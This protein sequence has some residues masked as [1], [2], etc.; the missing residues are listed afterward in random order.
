MLCTCCELCVTK[1]E[2]KDNDVIVEDGI[3]LEGERLINEEIWPVLLENEDKRGTVDFLEDVGEAGKI[4]DD[5]KPFEDC[6]GIEVIDNVLRVEEEADAECHNEEEPSRWIETP[7]GLMCVEDCKM[8]DDT[9]GGFIEEKV[10]FDE[11]TYLLEVA[12]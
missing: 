3:E 11:G 6:I 10:D 5:T 8:E 12:I 9:G 4:F 7:K 1:L 2:C